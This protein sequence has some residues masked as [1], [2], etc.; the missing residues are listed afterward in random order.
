MMTLRLRT[1]STR[2]PRITQGITPWLTLKM[3]ASATEFVLRPGYEG[4]I[5]MIGGLKA[6]IAHLM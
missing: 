4:V 3:F 5:D 2:K 1:L 6:V